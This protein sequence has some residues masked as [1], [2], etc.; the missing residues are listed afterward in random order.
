VKLIYF[1]TG[2]SYHFWLQ[3]RVNV[4]SREDTT[5]ILPSSDEICHGREWVDQY[6]FI[7]EYRLCRVGSGGELAGVDY[8]CYI[9]AGLQCHVNNPK[10]PLWDLFIVA[11]HILFSY[12]TPW[13]STKLIQIL[14]RR[15]ASQGRC[16]AIGASHG[17]SS[18]GRHPSNFCERCYL[19]TDS[20]LRDI[21]RPSVSR[22][23]SFAAT[24]LVERC[25]RVGNVVH[26][27]WT[28]GARWIDKVAKMCMGHVYGRRSSGDDILWAVLRR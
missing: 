22:G 26:D 15:R 21:L 23:T 10:A 3:G 11:L 7:Y 8:I 2:G 19:P 9:M 28:S 16:V 25:Q 4:W 1:L 5:I 27:K 20:K 14:I 24:K 6:M 12:V 13:Y 17:S 18:S